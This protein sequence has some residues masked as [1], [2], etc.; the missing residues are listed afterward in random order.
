MTAMALEGHC[1][2]R[3]DA[4][5]DAFANNFVEHGEV[6]AA[7]TV[8]VDGVAVVD[9]WGGWA[10]E[11]HTRPWRRDTLVNSYSVGKAFVATLL[12][13]LVDGGRVDLDA[14]I[15]TYWPAF[16]A[17]ARAKATVRHALCH[18]AG[19]PAIREPLTN[20]DLWDFDRMCD[21]VAATEPWWTPG[22]RHAYHTNTYGH[23]VG[24]I[25]R[26]VTGELPG[27][28]LA[29]LAAPLEADVH[30]GLPD[31]DHAR[32]ADTIWAAPALP[33]ERAAIDQLQGD[34]LMTALGYV[35][36]PGYASMGVVNTPE[37]RRT[38][39]P[40]TNGHM[41][42]H[43]IAR[44]Y[45]ALLRGDILSRDVLVEATRPQ[46]SGFCPTLGQ[47]VTFGLGF[48]PWTEKRPIGRTPSGF[49]HFGTGG[50]LGF[51]DPSVGVA[52]G[53]VM[54]HVIPRWQSPRNRA[55]VDA[56]YASLAT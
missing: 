20:D 51:A 44:I 15:A 43:G 49:G 25:V 32:C 26:H 40:S 36:P 1:D 2:S 24:G 11:A 47:D 55:L 6:G 38:Q 41:T 4:V 56:V 34:A 35:N 53:Y 17:G 28:R 13:Q 27:S 19:V 5:R 52:F 54:N 29:A 22:E 30:F 8:I 18:R 10:D 21:A 50:S 7:V 14:P 48:Q 42:A 23:L 9:L 33:S 16:A 37:W 12:L 3:F 31:A 39:V 45:D 46:S